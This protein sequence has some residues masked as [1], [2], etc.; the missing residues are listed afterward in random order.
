M[1]VD[2]DVLVAQA[3]MAE[4]AERYEDMTAAVKQLAEEKPELTVEE[5]NL[6]SVAYKNVVG[7]ARASWRVL[8]SVKAKQSDASKLAII[9]SFI[10]KVEKELSDK[11]AELLALV[12]HLVKT[13]P[14]TQAT[15]FYLK[16]AGDY[17]RYL[18]EFKQGSERDGAIS[19]ARDQ[20]E[21]A[22]KA[23]E[24]LKQTDPIRLGLALNYSVFYYEIIQESKTATDIAKS[25]FDSAISEL[26]TLQEDEYK[27]ATLIMQLIRDNLSLW[28]ADAAD[29]PV[30]ENDG[31][32]VEEMS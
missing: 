12:D 25:A 11:C 26:D 29:Q 30:T 19:N 8:T 16:M 28:N 32:E 18:A 7:A 6:L 3:K 15:V 27:D 14:D 22:Q 17:H 4:M 10:A 13:N 9:D 31:T 21:R 23:A 2:L 24:D 20:Y 1:P 5:R